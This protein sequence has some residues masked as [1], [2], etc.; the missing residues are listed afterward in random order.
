MVHAHLNVLRVQLF[1]MKQQESV[2]LVH[3]YVRHVR[4]ISTTVRLAVQML[5]STMVHAL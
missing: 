3:Q 2:M 1:P 5:H 4:G